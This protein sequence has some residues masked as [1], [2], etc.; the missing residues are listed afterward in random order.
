MDDWK[1]R[2]QSDVTTLKSDFQYLRNEQRTMAHSIQ[3][4][5]V[6]HKLHDQEIRSL[7]EALTDIKSDTQWIRRKITGAIISAVATAAIGTIIAYA[8]SQLWGG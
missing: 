5:E 7:K 3:S 6:S 2:M 8:V 1:E 4:L